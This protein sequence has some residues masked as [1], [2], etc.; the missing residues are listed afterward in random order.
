MNKTLFRTIL[1]ILSLSLILVLAG[2][3]DNP[4]DAVYVQSVAAINNMGSVGINNRFAGVTVSGNT[5]EVQF[6]K[7]MTLEKVLVEVG[8]TVNKGD[9]LFTYNDDALRLTIE[10]MNLEIESMRNSVSAYKSQINELSKE[11]S[12]VSDSE[13]LRY[14]LEIQGLEADI[15]ETEYNIKTKQAELNNRKDLAVDATVKAEITGKVTEI[16]NTDEYNEFGEQKPFIT[17]V[18]SGNLRIKGTINE[19]NRG[20]LSE[21]QDVIIRSR[22]DDTVWTGTVT[23][24]DWSATEKPNQGGYY[25]Y[26]EM[27]SSS[28]YPF[29]VAVD[30]SDGLIIGQ[31]VY[32]ELGGDTDRT[33]GIRI[34][35]YFINDAE[36]S[37]W[38]WASSGRDKLEKRNITLGEFD[39]EMQEYI[40][41]SGLTLD[42]Y[43]AFPQEGLK[44]GMPTTKIDTSEQDPGMYPEGESE[45]FPENEGEFGEFEEF[46]PD[47]LEGGETVTDDVITD[48]TVEESPEQ[49]NG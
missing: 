29:Y 47:E 23:T 16:N 17:I 36:S 20:S 21:G 1:L 26:D 40:V 45:F 14:T 38:V 48:G 46:V 18:E 37:P 15:R 25:G 13:K 8:Q 9:V 44:S 22:T 24:I 33:E 11:R 43:I 12:R 28:K 34:P 41:E 31:H 7:S 39:E 4:E 5:Q 27:S 6:D 32:I 35:A 3:N 49:E 30:D 42:D 10:Q 19:M 2:C